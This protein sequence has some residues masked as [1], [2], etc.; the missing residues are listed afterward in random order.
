MK[1]NID[2]TTTQGATLLAALAFLVIGTGVSLFH[3]F[4]R[5]V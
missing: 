4:A 2:R 3:A 1:R 5:M